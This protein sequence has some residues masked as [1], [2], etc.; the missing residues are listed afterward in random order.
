MLRTDIG[1]LILGQTAR[2]NALKSR[3]SEYGVVAVQGRSGGNLFI[4]AQEGLYAARRPGGVCVAAEGELWAAALSLAVQLCVDRVALIA[5]TDYPNKSTDEQEKQIARLKG[6]A[7]RN[8]FFCVSEVLVLE[9]GGDARSQ[10]RM[11]SVLRRLCN[12]RVYRLSAQENSMMCGEDAAIETAACF[13]A[14]GELWFSLAK[15]H[16]MCII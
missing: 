6:F 16:K 3:L 1:C 10:K 15:R 2:M 7:R 8:L 12:A 13:L 14:D 4:S 9:S 11:D 5:P